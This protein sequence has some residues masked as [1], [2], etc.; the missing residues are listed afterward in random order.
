MN[1]V[2]QGQILCE[3]ILSKGLEQG[4]FFSQK[5]TKIKLIKTI[6]L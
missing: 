3:L 1:D 2:K 5:L 6:C 4:L